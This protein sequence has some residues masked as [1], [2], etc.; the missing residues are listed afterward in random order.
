MTLEQI[1]NEVYKIINDAQ[2]TISN[3]APGVFIEVRTNRRKP[4][5]LNE[6]ISLVYREFKFPRN[7]GS[8]SPTYLIPRQLIMYVLKSHKACTLKEMG[9]VFGGRDH[10][11]VVNGIQ[12]AKDYIDVNSNGCRELYHQIDGYIHHIL[13]V[14]TRIAIREMDEIINH[15]TKV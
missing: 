14:N 8:R 6:I 10:S 11:T 13:Q 1:P 3:I 5:S 7:D 12:R 2:A 9:K 15:S 4:I